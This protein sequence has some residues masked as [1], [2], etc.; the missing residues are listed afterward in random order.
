MY[1]NGLNFYLQVNGRAI[2]EYFKDNMMYVEGRK[3]SNYEIVVVNNTVIRKKFVVSVDGLNVISGDKTWERGYVIGPY[4][5]LKIP[6]WRVD[7]DKVAKFI[8]SSV[9]ASYNQHNDSGD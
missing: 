4:Q 3:G 2:D 1:K 5:T 8:F 6:G 7:A 9:N